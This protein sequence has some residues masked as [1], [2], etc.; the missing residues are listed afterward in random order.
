MQNTLDIAI[1]QARQQGAAKIDSLTLKIGELSGVIS[2]ALEFAFEVLIKDTIAEDARLE[3]E[4]IPVKC[5]CQQC[6]L[7][8]QPE[9][10]I[11]Q[12]LECQQISTD[13]VEGRELELVSLIVSC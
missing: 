13:I 12:C 4:T 5:Y 3:I 9:S 11:Y 7:I 2:E 8:F 1:S 6:D 10:Y